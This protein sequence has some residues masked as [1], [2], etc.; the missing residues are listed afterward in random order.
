MVEVKI[1]FHP[2]L[3]CHN[4]TNPMTGLRKKLV[5][6]K[7]ECH[8]LPPPLTGNVSWNIWVP[9]QLTKCQRPQKFHDTKQ[10][11]RAAIVRRPNDTPVTTKWHNCQN[12]HC[13]DTRTWHHQERNGHTQIIRA[14]KRQEMARRCQL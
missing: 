5:T 10:N 1:P 7:G 8:H 6:V 14:W 4:Y 12:S 9:I 13:S 11:Y 2:T 3:K